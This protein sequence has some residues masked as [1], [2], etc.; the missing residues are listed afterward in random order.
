VA[1]GNDAGGRPHGGGHGN[2]G[3][4]RTRNGDPVVIALPSGQ[5][6]RV[7]PRHHREDVLLRLLT[8]GVSPTCLR[9][10]LPEWNHLILQASTRLE[11]NA[12]LGFAIRDR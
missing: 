6:V 12:A 4:T 7:D 2:L 3:T 11:R 9:A 10:L 5:E 8:L 1:A